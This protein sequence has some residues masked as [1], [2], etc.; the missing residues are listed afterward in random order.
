VLV[1]DHAPNAET[2]GDAGL[3][4]SGRGGVDDLADRLGRLLDDPELVETYRELARERS[5]RY[6]WDAVADEYERLLS[7]VRR[8]REPGSLPR[9]LVDVDVPPPAVGVSRP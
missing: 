9:E 8:R 6:S 7:D 5:K 3:Y 4:F 1:N 2:V